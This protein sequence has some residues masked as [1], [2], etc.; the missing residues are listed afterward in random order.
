MWWAIEAHC[1]KSFWCGVNINSCLSSYNTWWKSLFA[2]CNGFCELCRWSCPFG[3]LKFSR[4]LQATE[5]NLLNHYQ[6]QVQHQ[7]C[8]ACE[9][10]CLLR[11]T[12]GTQNWKFWPRQCALASEYLHHQH[13]LG[14]A[15]SDAWSSF[16]AYPNMQGNS[17]KLYL[18]S[19]PEKN[20]T[21][22]PGG[23]WRPPKLRQAGLMLPLNF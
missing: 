20:L 11:Q 5:R 7:I 23:S 18:P 10:V 6:Q 8:E 19:E 9:V 17:W 16:K 1:D 12:P 2:E 21:G 3:C 13:R 4:P 14:A 22:L 15:W